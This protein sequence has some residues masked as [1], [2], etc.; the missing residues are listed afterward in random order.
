MLSWN[1]VIFTHM[2]FGLVPEVFNAINMGLIVGKFI[3]T[4][5]DSIMFF[6]DQVNQSVVASPAVGV[7]RALKVYPCPGSPLVASLWS[8]WEL[9]LCILFHCV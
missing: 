3:V 5:L 9:F 4:M 7:D 2:A 8:S 1:T 6:V